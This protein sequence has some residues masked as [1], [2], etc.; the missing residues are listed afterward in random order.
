MREDSEWKNGED[1]RLVDICTGSKE[2]PKQ[3]KVEQIGRAP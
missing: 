2:E 3:E 1:E